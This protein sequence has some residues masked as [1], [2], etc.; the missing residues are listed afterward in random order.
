MPGLPVDEPPPHWVDLAIEHERRHQ[1][2]EAE[3]EAQRQAEEDQQNAPQTTAGIFAEAIAGA[4]RTSLPLNGAGV[5]RAAL[6]GMGGHGTING[7][8]IS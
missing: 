1:Q 2:Y 7:G 8:R 6:S 4:S 3:R 5:L